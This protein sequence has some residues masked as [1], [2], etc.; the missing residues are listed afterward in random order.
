MHQAADQAL[1]RMQSLQLAASRLQQ[2]F[3]ESGMEPSAWQRRATSTQDL[4]HIMQSASPHQLSRH[5]SLGS[6]A[7]DEASLLNGGSHGPVGS[8]GSAPFPPQLRPRHSP[9]NW[10]PRV[11]CKAA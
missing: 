2:M 9:W 3:D 11:R 10:S 5:L 6:E 8:H 4:E 7:A 1:S